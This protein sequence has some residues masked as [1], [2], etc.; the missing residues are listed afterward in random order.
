MNNKAKAFLIWCILIIFLGLL[1]LIY[2][3]ALAPDET[4]HV[5]RQIYLGCQELP[6]KIRRSIINRKL[7]KLVPL[8]GPYYKKIYPPHT[9][10][11]INQGKEEICYENCYQRLYRIQPALNKKKTLLHQ[12]T[13]PYLSQNTTS[14]EITS[15]QKQ[16][17]DLSSIKLHD[18]LFLNYI[19]RHPNY[20]NEIIDIGI[21]HVQISLL[22]QILLWQEKQ[23]KKRKGRAKEDMQTIHDTTVYKI[24]NKMFDTGNKILHKSSNE[25]LQQMSQSI[26]PEDAVSYKQQAMHP[27]WPLEIEKN[28]HYNPEELKVY[29]YWDQ[30]KLGRIQVLLRWMLWKYSLPTLPHEGGF[31]GRKLASDVHDMFYSILEEFWLFLQQQFKRTI[32]LDYQV[33][34]IITDYVI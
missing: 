12:H 21:Q 5:I 19:L 8:F 4:E 16:Q 6:G 18:T 29:N 24:Y 14:H 30:E 13:A 22:Q 27:I 7:N 9:H 3:Y 20:M 15:L 25:Y 34:H 17:E 32:H 28:I 31:C 2:A 33:L 1:V 23:I 10:F 26:L 11:R